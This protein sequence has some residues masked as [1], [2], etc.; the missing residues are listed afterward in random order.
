MYKHNPRL[1][2][3]CN[4]QYKPL[5]ILL[6]YLF[7]GKV[8]VYMTKQNY[9]KYDCIEKGYIYNT[10]LRRCSPVRRPWIANHAIHDFALVRGPVREPK[11]RLL[12]TYKEKEKILH[13]LF[14]DDL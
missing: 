7:D 6:Q 4:R 1:L 14:I 5:H 11:L 2:N 9:E 10:V 8:F 3:F 13:T 12:A